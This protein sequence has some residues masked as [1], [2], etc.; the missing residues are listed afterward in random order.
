MS[1][2]Q[3]TQT[4][5][6]RP[7]SYADIER[8]AAGE[9]IEAYR[10]EHDGL[11]AA[12]LTAKAH[13]VPNSRYGLA[14]QPKFVEA[15]S[16]PVY[17]V[18]ERKFPSGMTEK[19]ADKDNVVGQ[20]VDVAV[21]IHPSTS[22]GSTFYTTLAAE[23]V[24]DSLGH[25]SSPAASHREHYVVADEQGE[26]R[27]TVPL[28]GSQVSLTVFVKEVDDAEALE[29]VERA[30]REAL[31]DHKFRIRKAQSRPVL[32]RRVNV[33]SGSNDNEVLAVGVLYAETSY[34]KG[35]GGAHRIQ[36]LDMNSTEIGEDSF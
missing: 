14:A 32:D 7:L 10:V 5:K 18:T 30:V 24:V 22:T 31:A 19:V 3:R 28:F 4:V 8:L 16:K 15:H 13:R 29:V 1:T 6:V 11:Q 20:Q 36:Y 23:E 12:T 35:A 33:Y 25:R 21:H 26:E 2:F 27:T 34:V 17:A 9:P